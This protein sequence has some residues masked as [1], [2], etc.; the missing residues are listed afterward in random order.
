MELN[1]HCMPHW[2][3][4]RR[5]YVS[6]KG[7]LGLGV[8]H[9]FLQHRGSPKPHDLLRSGGIFLFGYKLIIFYP[10]KKAHIY[11][12]KRPPGYIKECIN[13]FTAVKNDDPV[14]FC[15]YVCGMHLNI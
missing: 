15:M 12:P 10:E 4:R 8:V 11:K 1:T 9:R 13:T 2:L 6:W 14:F 5:R 7:D 3:V